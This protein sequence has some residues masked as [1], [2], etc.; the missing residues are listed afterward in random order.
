MSE[1]VAQGV[2]IGDHAAVAFAASA[3]GSMR[4]LDGRLVNAKRWLLESELSFERHDVFGSVPTIRAFQ[5]CVAAAAH[6]AEGAS[7]A[8]ERCRAALAG[9]EPFFHELPAI[10][11][12][13]AWTAYA[14]GDRMA[15]QGRL[16]DTAGEIGQSPV[17]AAQLAHDALLAGASAPT[18][19]ERLQSLHS[20]TDAPLVAAY[21]AH[22]HARADRD[23]AALMEASTESERIGAV[24]YATEA[25]AEAA[26][27]FMES[28]RHD[29]ARRAAT[30]ARDLFARGQGGTAPVIDGL[31]GATTGLTAREAQLVDL[32]RHGLSNP[33]IAER[34]VLSVRTIESHLYRAMQKLG[35]SD[36]RDL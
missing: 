8:L 2:R 33:Q 5:V 22:A 34:L 15:A 21:A 30:C 13:E 27:A 3:L 18:V 1:I 31:D 7:A 16:L 36:R 26:R 11:R 35:V 25:A 12:A 32:A 23:G 10:T 29:S 20:R 14:R 17:H 4:L 19:A 9:R 6:D 28:R 24:R